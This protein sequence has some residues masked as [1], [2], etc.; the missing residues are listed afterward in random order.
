MYSIGKVGSSTFYNSIK[1][2]KSIKIPIYHIHSLAKEK[3]AVQKKYYKNS[4]RKSIPMHLIQSSVI[5]EA[6]KSYSGKLYIFTLIR[7]PI[8][9][10]LSSIFQDSFNFTKQRN[11]NIDLIEKVITS[12]IKDLVEELPEYA[13]FTKELNEVFDIDVFELPFQYKSR[14]LL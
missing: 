11:L 2:S 9:R 3:I 13:W 5:S 4:K 8:S 10:E 1:K 7:E 12:K 6:L 14:I